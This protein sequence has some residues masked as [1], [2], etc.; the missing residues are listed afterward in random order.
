VSFEYAP[1]TVTYMD[2]MADREATTPESHARDELIQTIQKE[3]DEKFQERGKRDGKP[4]RAFICFSELQDIWGDQSRISSVI[5]G[6]QDGRKVRYIQEKMII[7]LSILIYIGAVNEFNNL[8]QSEGND[9]ERPI[10]TDADLPLNSNQMQSFIR[11][12]GHASYPRRS[13]FFTEQ[14]LFIPEHIPDHRSRSIMEVPQE[15]RLPFIWKKE[16]I[17]EG[18]FGEVSLIEV[19]KGY[20]VDPERNSKSGI[21][22]DQFYHKLHFQVC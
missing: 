12:H 16:I 7:I 17:G 11:T 6:L 13:A 18:G 10:L 19:P 5:P 14:Y 2:A 20:L 22:S 21:V 8:F 15:K 3:I 4:N 9:V 1:S